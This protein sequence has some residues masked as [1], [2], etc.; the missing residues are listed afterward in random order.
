MNFVFASLVA[1]FSMLNLRTP[2]VSS[3]AIRRP[4]SIWHVLSAP[5][6]NHWSRIKFVCG[7][8]GVGSNSKSKS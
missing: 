7:S 8:F 4:F 5:L 6:A 3:L 1:R 2:S